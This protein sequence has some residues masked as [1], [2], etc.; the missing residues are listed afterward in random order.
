MTK[1]LRRLLIVPLVVFHATTAGADRSS[2]SRLL[3]WRVVSTPVARVKALAVSGILAGMAWR[4]GLF[5]YR[6]QIKEIEKSD[7]DR[8]YTNFGHMGLAELGISVRYN[9]ERFAALNTGRPLIIVANH[10]LGIADG[11]A[12]QYI[13]SRARPSAP[14]LLFLARWIE[15]LLPFA[16]VGDARG[17]GTA[18]PIEINKLATT[19]PEAN[20]FNA[21][22]RKKALANLRS[23]GAVIA[24]P[25]G[26]VAPLVKGTAYPGGVMDDSW[27]EGF[28][29]IAR[30]SKA[31]IVFANVDA[32]NS[33]AFYRNRKRFGGGD[34]ERVFWFLSEAVAKRGQTIDVHLSRPMDLDEVY[35][36][37]ADKYGDSI[38]LL[39]ADHK[40]TAERMRQW[41]Y[42][43]VEDGAP[44]LDTVEK[45][46]ANAR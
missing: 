24:F 43:M 37:L 23:A 42:A 38:G 9:G 2:C 4:R 5:K 29:L 32:V 25:A 30:R 17:W 41:V 34:Q 6:K 40:S 33:E 45:P 22:S 36:M 31:Q 10:H 35:G 27:Q 11:L 44:A 7:Y 8:A 26:H 12:M 1:S 16:V 39:K 13:T 20:H 3:W 28:L 46:I 21:E 14:S 15:K 18:L 19:D